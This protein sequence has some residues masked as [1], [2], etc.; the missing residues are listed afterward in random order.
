MT[1]PY[2]TYLGLPFRNIDIEPLMVFPSC[3]TSRRAE[4]S[5]KKT[6]PAALRVARLSAVISAAPVRPRDVYSPF[7]RSADS[8]VSA[9]SPP[10]CRPYLLSSFM[11]YV[12]FPP[13]LV[14]SLADLRCLCGQGEQSICFK[15]VR[16]LNRFQSLQPSNPFQLHIMVCANRSCSVHPQ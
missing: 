3:L 16:Y 6:T 11:H 7:E 8:A 15:S 10:W 9:C 13:T 4:H 5:Q 12:P 1:Q 2:H 14:V